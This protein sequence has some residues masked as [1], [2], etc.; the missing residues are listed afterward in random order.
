VFF[1]PFNGFGCNGGRSSS[2]KFADSG[3]SVDSERSLAAPDVGVRP[4][5]RASN[6]KPRVMT[7]EH[8]FGLVR[9]KSA[10]KHRFTVENAS[11]SNWTVKGIDRTCACTVANIT[12]PVIKAGTSE[13]IEVVYRSGQ[14][15]SDDRRSITVHFIE[16]AAPRLDLAVKACV[17]PLLLA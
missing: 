16:P 17:R 8:D 10:T 13:Q 12:S 4:H 1:S 9:P 3:N 5:A 14:G 11:G 7:L 2:D 15:A 6:V